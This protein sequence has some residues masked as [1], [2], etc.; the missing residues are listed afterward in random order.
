M[1]L[2][3]S[4]YKA[5]NQLNSQNGKTPILPIY[6]LYAHSAELAL[7]SYI[8]KITNDESKLRSIG[9]NLQEAFEFC[10]AN[11]IGQIIGDTAPLKDCIS[12]INEQYEGKELEYHFKGIKQLPD[13]KQFDQAVQNLI[14]VLMGKYRAEITM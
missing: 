14:A 1:N 13:P 6:Y 11:N 12:I 8:Y 3:E 7:K 9:H 10:T 5:A 2:A 4:F